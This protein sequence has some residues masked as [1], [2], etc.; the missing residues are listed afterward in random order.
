M[1]KMRKGFTLIEVLVVAVIVAVLAAVAIPAYNA[2]IRGSKEK[3]AINFAGTIASSAAT[4]YAQSQVY[5]TDIAGDLL[6]TSPSGYVGSV[7]GTNAY[8]GP[9]GTAP[10]YMSTDFDQQTVLWKG[11]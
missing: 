8:A 2:Y 3:V 11:N 7:D 1:K 9:S 10:G 4:Y 5:P 6:I